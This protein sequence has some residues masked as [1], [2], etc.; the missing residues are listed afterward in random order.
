V[1]VDPLERR[2]EGD[3]LALARVAEREAEVRRER[4]EVPR[5][6]LVLRPHIAHRHGYSFASGH[7]PRAQKKIPPM[8]VTRQA[9]HMIRAITSLAPA[10]HPT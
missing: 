3:E 8:P 2:G 4:G 7:A 6:R 9:Y 1:A 5:E 10:I